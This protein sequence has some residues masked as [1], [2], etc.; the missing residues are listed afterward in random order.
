M[1]YEAAVYCWYS[2]HRRWVWWGHPLWLWLPVTPCVSSHLPGNLIGPLCYGLLCDWTMCFW[3]P[4][5]CSVDT[6]ALS[7]LMGKPPPG[8][9]TPWR[10]AV[11]LCCWQYANKLLK[12]AVSQ[13]GFQLPLHPIRWGYSVALSF[14]PG[15]KYVNL[16]IKPAVS[17]TT[18][19][20]GFIPLA[21]C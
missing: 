2:I 3:F 4:Q 5:M 10:W 18:L 17:P 7:L 1:Q 19:G 15:P 14:G 16:V 13:K 9:P 20:V 11:S 12:P 6:M 8:R 21:I